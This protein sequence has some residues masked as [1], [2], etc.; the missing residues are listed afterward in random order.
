MNT[1]WIHPETQQAPGFTCDEF[2]ANFDKDEKAMLSKGFRRKDYATIPVVEP[3][4]AH[5]DVRWIQ[6]PNR[7][8]YAVYTCRLVDKIAEEQARVEA[9]QA[10]QAQITATVEAEQ[11]ERTSI[12]ETLAT[13]DAKPFS[14][15]Q[16]PAITAIKTL[17]SK[18]LGVS[19]K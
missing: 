16:A 9:E 10:Q 8:E 14:A 12:E 6:D 5:A 11:R 18:L 1:D 7:K 4:F 2:R 13:I 15:E 17:L 3:G 19:L